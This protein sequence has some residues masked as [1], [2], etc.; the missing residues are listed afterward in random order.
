MAVNGKMPIKLHIKICGN[1]LLL[2]PHFFRLYHRLSR[3]DL[4]SLE[5]RSSALSHIY[6]FIC[7]SYIVYFYIFRFRLD[8]IS[9]KSIFF[10]TIKFSITC[11]V[12][13]SRLNQHRHETSWEISNNTRSIFKM[14]SLFGWFDSLI[15]Y[16]VCTVYFTDISF[17]LN[18][19]SY[20][21]SNFIDII[22]GWEFIILNCDIW[23]G[24]EHVKN[25]VFIE[26]EKFSFRLLRLVKVCM[27][28]D[29]MGC[30]ETLQ[31]DKFT[32]D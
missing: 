10:C 29:F 15:F 14:F 1:F 13:R 12:A 9:S 20:R 18:F 7:K 6:S 26:S 4:K 25:D 22:W 8:K 28:F 21:Y 24:G 5:K 3:T 2:P 31:G 11:Q 32:R 19:T 30:D 16:V 17:S 27:D 23:W